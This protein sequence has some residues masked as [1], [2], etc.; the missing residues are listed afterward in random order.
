MLSNF[1]ETA[2]LEWLICLHGPSVVNGKRGSEV[3]GTGCSCL[4]LGWVPSTYVAH[5]PVTPV[6]GDLALSSALHRHQTHTVHKHACKI[7]LKE[8]QEKRKEKEA[9]L[10]SQ[11]FQG[12]FPC[13]LTL[14]PQGQD[15]SLLSFL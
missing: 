9:F 6:P 12:S 5:N 13:F 8:K 15:F 2:Q 3:Q 4:G 1:P 11:S 10:T 14:A 7:E